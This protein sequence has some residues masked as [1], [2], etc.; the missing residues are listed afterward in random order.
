MDTIDSDDFYSK[1][2]QIQEETDEESIG[3][4]T[5]RLAEEQEKEANALEDIKNSIYLQE[6]NG[7]EVSFDK[8]IYAS[9]TTLETVESSSNKF[10]LESNSTTNEK[11]RTE[12]PLSLSVISNEGLGA[13]DKFFSPCSAYKVPALNFSKMRKGNGVGSLN[14]SCISTANA[15]FADSR[16]EARLNES[17]NSK[18]T[19]TSFSKASEQSSGE[20]PGHTKNQLSHG[21]LTNKLSK[22]LKKTNGHYWK[23]VLQ[24]RRKNSEGKKVSWK[25]QKSRFTTQGS[26]NVKI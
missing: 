20:K 15:S 14:S 12:N 19:P 8:D 1:C 6:K 5:P 16:I 18:F 9:K 21:K 7:E 22:T 4:F 25:D 13:D 2:T 3:N 23:T 10:E 17:P 11:E 24:H 26:K